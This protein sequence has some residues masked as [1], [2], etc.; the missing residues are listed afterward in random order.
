MGRRR[1]EG[2]FQADP[3]RGSINEKEQNEILAAIK[4][5]LERYHQAETLFPSIAQAETL[6]EKAM[7][8]VQDETEV[9][10]IAL[11]LR[12]KWNLGLAPIE[13]MVSLLEE[14]G[15][16]VVFIQAADSFDACAFWAAGKPGIVA[17]KGLPGD[18]LRFNHGS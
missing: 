4:D 2:A 10:Q 6:S 1:Q 3:R 9:E 18:R 8:E 13:N 5:W 16:R 11:D 7:I 14:H 15:I 12:G 17:R